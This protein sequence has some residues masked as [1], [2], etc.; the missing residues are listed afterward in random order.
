MSFFLLQHAGERAGEQPV[1][2]T[3]HIKALQPHGPSCLQ[4]VLSD[5][6]IQWPRSPGPRSVLPWDGQDSLPGLLTSYK[7]AKH[8]GL[9]LTG[10]GGQQRQNP[11]PS[12]HS[13]PQVSPFSTDQPRV[14]PRNCQSRHGLHHVENQLRGPKWSPRLASA[15][16][17]DGITRTLPLSHSA[18]AARSLDRGGT[19]LPRALVD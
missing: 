12:P 5:A 1:I 17:W 14:T 4:V 3:Q 16:I 19:R 18:P 6:G 9:S 15:G 11:V 7:V 10:P 8:Q 2:F 13:S